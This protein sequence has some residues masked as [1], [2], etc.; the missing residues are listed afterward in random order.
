[1]ID[2]YE[3]T[4]GGGKSY[5]AWHRALEYIAAGGCVYTN[6]TLELEPFRNERYKQ[7]ARG[8]RDY[9]RRRYGWEYQEGQYVQLSNDE[10][11][12]L[13]E[14]V[15]PGT[16]DH[17]VLVLVDEA[18]DFFNS[19]D[20]EQSKTRLRE[21]LSFLQHS[22]KCCIDVI[23]ITQ[24]FTELNSRIRTKV[25]GYYRLADV[26]KL[27]LPHIGVGFPWPFTRNFLRVQYNRTGK[28]FVRRQWVAKDEAVFGCYR[29]DEMFRELKL[30]SGQTDFRGQGQSED[31]M[32]REMVTLVIGAMVVA[33]FAVGFSWF[34]GRGLRRELAGIRAELSQEK[35]EVPDTKKLEMEVSALKFEL[36]QSV[37]A[38]RKSLVSKVDDGPV[39]QVEMGFSKVNGEIV[40]HYGGVEYRTDRLTGLGLVKRVTEDMVQI[41]GHKGEMIYLVPKTGGTVQPSSRSKTRSRKPVYTYTRSANGKVVNSS[42]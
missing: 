26:A 40:A 2:I 9:L 22:R 34:Q 27:R 21:F 10:L 3:G 31:F 12:R 35:E 5:C 28:V 14:L 29:T 11:Y 33:L 18:L 8:A 7:D 39:R 15:P 24:E 20:R 19:L 1:M 6:M 13:H 4:I 38:L 23:F 30:G 36:R 25:T 42:W 41:Q 16:P 32:K 37:A 17:P